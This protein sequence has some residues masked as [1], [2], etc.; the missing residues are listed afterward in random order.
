[1]E[2]KEANLGKI[3]TAQEVSDLLRIPLS[4]IYDLAAKG[5][6]RGVKFGKHWRFLEEEIIRYF[7]GSWN[8]SKK[9]I[10]AALLISFIVTNHAN[11]FALANPFSR[12]VDADISRPDFP[13][14][15]ARVQVPAEI[16]KIEEI[17][18]IKGQESFP[19]SRP[20]PLAPFV[21]LIQDAHA[22]P[23]AQTSIQQLIGHF[24][25]EYGVGLVALEGASNPLDTQ[26]FRS[27]PDREVLK[28]VFDQYAKQ[29]ELAGGPAAAIFG[30]TQAKY[31]G[32]EDWPL[33]EEGIR[34]YQEAMAKDEVLLPLLRAA[35]DRL[36]KEKEKV[37]SK[38][39]LEID[40]ILKDFRANRT[41]LATVLKQLQIRGHVGIGL[42]Q[43]VPLSIQTLVDEIERE[44]RDQGSIDREVR[45][46]AE[47][48]RLSLRAPKGRSNLESKIA[49][50]ALLPRNDKRLLAFNQ[51]Y[52]EFQTSR[53]T[54]EAFVLYLKE[55]LD[56]LAQNRGQFEKNRFQPVPYF[57]R[58]L[59]AIRY[60]L[61]ANTKLTR[62]IRHQKRLRNIEG[63]RLFKEFEQYTQAV[64]ES[65]FRN[66]E[67]K[68]LDQQSERLRLLEAF[69]KLELSYDQWQEIQPLT[70]ILSPNGGEEISL[71]NASDPPRSL[72]EVR[73]YTT[74][75][76]Q[77]L[78]KMQ[79][80][81]AFYETASA[82]DQVF[83]EKLE[84]LM[85]REK[86]DA[87]IMVT[88]GFHARQLTK[89]FK[90]NGISYALVIPKIES[91]PGE[92]NYRAQMAGD[93]SWKNY[94]EIEKGRVNLYKAFVRGARDKLLHEAGGAVLTSANQNDQSQGRGARDKLLGMSHESWVLRKQEDQRNHPRLTTQDSRLLLKSWRD[95]IIRDLAGQNRI[96]D[97]SQY[98]RFLDEITSHESQA[99]SHDLVIS[100][101]KFAAGLKQLHSTGQLNQQNITSLL[102][103]VTT[104]TLVVAS[105]DP[106]AFT[107]SYSLLGRA[108]VRV[109]TTGNEMASVIEGAKEL[110]TRLGSLTKKYAQRSQPEGAFRIISAT[111]DPV[112]QLMR[113]V[114]NLEKF[115]LD[116]LAG[117]VD[118]EK[119]GI[120]L[121]QIG[122]AYIEMKDWMTSNP[123]A[124]GY[125]HFS[126][127]LQELKSIL[128]IL[129]KNLAAL[130]RRAGT[131]TVAPSE[132]EAHI[133]D[134][135]SQILEAYDTVMQNQQTPS[136]GPY[137]LDLIYRQRQEK[138]PAINQVKF[139][140]ARTQE[141]VP[142]SVL[143]SPPLIPKEIADQMIHRKIRR[144]HFSDEVMVGFVT[145]GELLRALLRAVLQSPANEPYNGFEIQTQPEQDGFLHIQITYP[146]IEENPEDILLRRSEMRN[147]QEILEAYRKLG[148]NRS[149]LQ[150]AAAESEEKALKVLNELKFRYVDILGFR[151]S[152]VKDAKLPDD[153]RRQAR[154]EIVGNDLE[155]VL[156]RVINDLEKNPNGKVFQDFDNAVFRLRMHNLFG[157]QLNS[158]DPFQKPDAEDINRNLLL[159]QQ[160]YEKLGLNRA[161]ILYRLE[162]GG[163][164]QPQ[165]QRIQTAYRERVNLHHPLL[166]IR[167]ESEAERAQPRI[168]I[169]KLNEALLEWIA[170]EVNAYLE[171]I[172]GAEPFEAENFINEIREAI[173]IP[174]RQNILNRL[175]SELARAEREDLNL[176]PFAHPHMARRRTVRIYL[177][178]LLSESEGNR[179]GRVSSSLADFIIS[180]IPHARSIAEHRPPVDFPNFLSEVESRISRYNPADY[181]SR[182]IS[183]F[184]RTR[185][186]D[187]MRQLKD[188]PKDNKVHRKAEFLFDL[189]EVWSRFAGAVRVAVPFNNTVSPFREYLEWSFL[190]TGS[191]EDQDAVAIRL[192]SDLLRI[193]PI[194][195]SSGEERANEFSQRIQTEV[196]RPLNEIHEGIVQIL[197]EAAVGDQNLEDMDRYIQEVRSRIFGRYGQR[198]DALRRRGDQIIQ[199]FFGPELGDLLI[200]GVRQ[201][202]I[203]V[204]AM[205]DG[206]QAASALRGAFT[207]FFEDSSNSPSHLLRELFR[208]NPPPARTEVRENTLQAEGFRFQAELGSASAISQ[209]KR[210]LSADVFREE[211]SLQPRQWQEI[212]LERFR[213]PSIFQFHSSIL[214]PSKP[215]SKTHNRTETNTP[216]HKQLQVESMSDELS[217]P[218]WDL[219]NENNSQLRTR[220]SEL[221]LRS[222]VRKEI[223]PRGDVNVFEISRPQ[224]QEGQQ[225]R[226][227]NRR[228]WHLASLFSLLFWVGEPTILSRIVPL[229]EAKSQAEFLLESL[230]KSL[231]LVVPQKEFW[232]SLAAFAPRL[233]VDLVEAFLPPASLSLGISIQEK[234]SNININFYIS[235]IIKLLHREIARVARPELRAT[236]LSRSEMPSARSELRT[237]RGVRLSA[238]RSELRNQDEESDA[239]VKRA[240]EALSRLV[241][242]PADYDWKAHEEEL[243]AE[244]LLDLTGLP[245]GE[246]YREGTIRFYPVP[247]F[248]FGWSILGK[249]EPGWKAR[250]VR[251]RLTELGYE[252]RVKLEKEGEKAFERVFYIGRAIRK[253]LGYQKQRGQR[254]TV[255]DIISDPEAL[256][257]QKAFSAISKLILKPAAYD[258]KAH[259][260]ELKAEGL[261]D[262][263]GLSLGE[264][265]Q[266][267]QIFFFP[268]PNF[269]YQWNILG[270]REAGW[271]AR[272]TGHRV[273]NLG[274][275]LTVKFEK[276]GEKA[277]EGV[278]YI[279]RDIRK[280]LGDNNWPF[281]GFSTLKGQPFFKLSRE[282]KPSERGAEFPF[283]PCAKAI[284]TKLLNL[285]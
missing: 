224:Q 65:V 32:I 135:S 249:Q 61:S 177:N 75:E 143:P 66:E 258:W 243:K 217:K 219:D 69:V 47:Q 20:L 272:I 112:K 68:K 78:Q 13:S 226:L 194:P 111:P 205:P 96:A 28:K 236:I 208:R 216:A 116:Y 59:N 140:D 225:N 64:K 5:K 30:E 203:A 131:P 97:S 38:E 121:G 54:P 146:D 275:E 153:I 17:F 62:L 53:I 34:L 254:Q 23:Q 235:N 19:V 93:V 88:G 39:L 9:V 115:T 172:P 134:F 253:I 79:P 21:I 189:V 255:L 215:E 281:A 168:P 137:T 231:M 18:V 157:L 163:D 45:E 211:V 167:S 72:A 136:A 56:Q 221:F 10:T 176:G 240:K 127:D 171:R 105:F 218:K 60:R 160:A 259:A 144:I 99:A 114:E 161:S 267:G 241:F 234:L 29:G 101:Q 35:S 263:A 55:F 228:L 22:I 191:I 110:L 94:F 119:S 268:I 252:L 120:F 15:L 192:I 220:S 251:S 256:A 37:Y 246:I 125:R 213:R 63:T 8:F 14:D 270:K 104:Q 237:A 76:L 145:Q 98:T 51:K 74:G 58:K 129:E 175:V 285:L 158:S 185:S 266:H 183:E 195:I 265:A 40:R 223:K 139:S 48:V 196:I 207:A 148:F 109:L 184:I 170:P 31:V 107:N 108:E 188:K 103:T 73:G 227:K 123:P 41:D 229:R 261:L 202:E 222:E 260:E 279:G 250:I 187:M 84:V 233:R 201:S 244:G 181:R 128:E 248:L 174:I 44:G 179:D 67:E 269:T 49:S 247:N 3:M 151:L 77:L 7:R 159:I 27:F 210:V 264:T 274:Y 162:Q 180:A 193:T 198:L 271:K 71:Q 4:T 239:D 149:S 33:Y 11:A 43:P 150:K 232:Q 80:H 89:L 46:I 147:E 122:F 57:A 83:Y 209:G 82:R 70:L 214:S 130:L 52:Q 138:A 124:A 242:K 126:S 6:I 277:F 200:Q 16:G 284:E 133:A 280:I 165:I 106:T 12:H 278:F 173:E 199:E 100:A 166:R 92:T 245:L 257:K 26:I 178:L 102:K 1:M 276:E 154:A 36:E 206:T 118:L 25:K 190:H 169:E 164:W 141:Q 262:L 238:T 86:T 50:V 117:G 95:Q 42:F 197:G 113:L 87:A 24:Q 142:S 273:T 85:K 204:N 230:K 156:S 155:R 152:Q 283:D 186:Q 90:K 282:I 91:I 182:I 81:F 132:F 2:E 212:Q